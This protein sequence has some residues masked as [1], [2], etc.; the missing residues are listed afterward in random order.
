LT[1]AGDLVSTQPY[2]SKHQAA[3]PVNAAAGATVVGATDRTRR[4]QILDAALELFAES[5]SRGT[6]VA[7][8]AARVGITD[9]GVLYHFRTKEELLL[10]V[11]RHFDS[12]VEEGLADTGARGIDLLRLV[13]GWGAGMEK[14]PEIS[15]LLVVL[16]AEHLTTD[17]PARRYIQ[18]RY[19]HVLDRYTAAFATAAVVGDLRADLNPVHEASALVAHLDGIRLQWFL[20]DRSFSMADSV[21][22]YVDTTLARL[23]PR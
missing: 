19:R 17:S 6:S 14:R 22:T 15:S 21:R 18:Q 1:G 23:A 3:E 16:S 11:L 10:G 20:L 8:V 4:E 9:A 5:G 2:V 13:R 12:S 7:A